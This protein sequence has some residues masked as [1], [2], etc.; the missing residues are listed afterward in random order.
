V[1]GAYGVERG[2][3]IWRLKP[4]LSVEH[5]FEDNE[6]HFKLRFRFGVLPA[7]WRQ[8]AQRGVT[9]EYLPGWRGAFMKLEGQ[10]TPWVQS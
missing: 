8:R 4:K 1:Y 9:F 3:L 7:D 5:D 6:S 2:M 10:P